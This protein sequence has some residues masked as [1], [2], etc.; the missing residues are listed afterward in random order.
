MHPGNPGFVG[1]VWR[2]AKGEKFNLEILAE[3]N[4]C[5]M[6]NLAR[7]R[8]QVLPQVNKTGDEFRQSIARQ[9]QS[10]KI[11]YHGDDIVSEHGIAVPKA[12]AVLQSKAIT[13]SDATFTTDKL[14]QGYAFMRLLGKAG[15]PLLLLELHQR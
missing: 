13:V 14:R 4:A 1:E 8:V 9:V 11:Y 7:L 5:L 15:Y 2:V 3:L 10:E 6:E 12:K